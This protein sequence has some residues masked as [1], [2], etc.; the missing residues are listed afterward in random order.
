MTWARRPRVCA[1]VWEDGKGVL[2]G[3]IG[4]D[5]WLGP[6]AAVFTAVAGKASLCCM[7]AA[8]LHLVCMQ[9]CRRR[10]VSSQHV[11]LQECNWPLRPRLVAYCEPTLYV[12]GTQV[13]DC[14]GVLECT[15]AHRPKS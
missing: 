2:A 12:W 3:C 13:C 6:H 11:V 9:G 8:R 14:A 1:C 5:D 7:E 10:A 4:L 15:A